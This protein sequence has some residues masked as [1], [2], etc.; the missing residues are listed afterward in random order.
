MNPLDEP[1]IVMPKGHPEPIG[2]G[3]LLAVNRSCFSETDLF[4][5]R[6]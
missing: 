5:G 3:L 6:A 1:I 4:E 2:A